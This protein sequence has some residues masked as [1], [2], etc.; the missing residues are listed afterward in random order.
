MKR[1]LTSRSRFSLLGAAGLL[2]LCGILALILGL[3]EREPVPVLPSDA[4]GQNPLDKAENGV[5]L[6]LRTP[7]NEYF[8]ANFFPTE[9]GAV[10][11]GLHDDTKSI[12][13]TLESA[14]A[15]GGTVYLPKGTYRITEPLTVPSGVTLRG[16]FVSPDAGSSEGANTVL[17]VEDNE[18]T[19]S[20]PLL[21]LENDAS[22]MGITVYYE[23]QNPQDL[24]EYPVSVYCTGTN[25]VQK[26]TLINPYQGI[27][28]TGKGTVSLRNLWMSPLD[29]GVLITD[30]DTAVTIEDCSIRPTYWLNLIPEQFSQSNGYDQLTSYLYDNLHGVILE[31]VRDTVL[32]R[33][34]VEGA[35]VGVLY[36]IPKEQDSLPLA[37][38]LNVSASRQP[39]V[40][41]SLPRAG[42]LFTDSV[43]RPDNDSGANT[44]EIQKTVQTPV[45]FSACTF[46]GLP[47]TVIH[48][49]SNTFLSFYHC[50]FGTWW[51][52]CFETQGDTFLAVAPVFKTSAQ[53]AALGTGAFGLLY[54]APSLEASSQLLF[55]VPPE[56]AVGTKS[57]KSV[58]LKTVPP[59]AVVPV[60]YAT[61]YGASPEAKDNTEAL[62]KAF[63]AA[64]EKKAIVFL[65]EGTYYFKSPITVPESV[66]L[67]G[68]GST[69]LYKTSLMFDL[70]APT[71]RS[72]V[73]LD[74]FAGVEQV[75]ICQG[76]VSTDTDKTYGI[77]SSAEG[78]VL[79]N[80][81]ITASRGILLQ[82]AKTTLL[83]DLSLSVSKMGISLENTQSTT[84]H[85][86]TVTDE[87]KVHT[88]V[89]I[90]SVNAQATISCLR[91]WELI[92]PLQAEDSTI[93]GSLFTLRKT[94]DGIR[95]AGGQV[96]FTAVGCNTDQ[97]TTPFR[98]IRHTGSGTATL[99]GALYTGN[100]PE[101]SLALASA[102][103]VTLRAALI[104]AENT[105]TVTAEGSG[106]ITVYGSIWDS[107]PTYHATAAGGSVS[108]QANLLRSNKTFEGIEGSYV[109]SQTEEG[110]VED[111]VNVI[112][113]VYIPSEG[114][115]AES[116]T[117]STTKE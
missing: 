10:G 63:E 24:G 45:V 13:K 78:N 5:S 16:D 106:K 47:R 62:N 49:E 20:T 91:A 68:V 30:N 50:N 111:G 56:Q 105:A 31:K 43:L 26:L 8:S 3:S 51:D 66:R 75:M 2:L 107:Y 93:T 11:D 95:S 109:L 102:G 25:T 32:H 12:R 112:Q 110:T 69:G 14:G 67:I 87:S 15:S 33:V 100:T 84:L 117:G 9:A 46:G 96:L 39:L 116:G 55:S 53:K 92:C 57:D 21:T 104:T 35:A 85:G 23:G 99:Q 22:L 37:S 34:S 71:E 65:P 74:P 4:A 38:E 88:A 64:K 115:N 19:R 94:D 98:L 29:Y 18:S 41:Q 103:A 27:C 54:N 70:A 52:A 48:S 6:L 61:E 60:I 7:S 40:L 113:Y 42:A 108:L 17:I 89:G 77:F 44:V 101:G 1:S 59:S 58:S 83:E 97:V 36:N 90:R 76:S 114:E 72:L 79:R 86:I 82:G 73:H 28:V 80:L 81:C